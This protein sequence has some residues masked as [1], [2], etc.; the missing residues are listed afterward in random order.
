MSQIYEH[1][2]KPD[3]IVE[4]RED[5][6][7]SRYYNRDMA[8]TTRMQR[9]WG[10]RDMAALWVSMSACIPSYMIASGLISSGMNWWQAVLTVLLGNLIVLIPMV[11]NAHAGT[12]YGIPYPVYCR[13]SFGLRGA[14]IPAILR[15]LVACGWFGIQTWI[16]G[17]GIY[18]ALVVLFD[19]LKQMPPIISGIN[20]PQLLCFLAF[21]A[22]NMWIIYRGIESVRIFLNLATPVLIA[23]PIALLIWAWMKAGGAGPILSQPSQFVPGG[24]KQ[25]LFWAVFFPSLTAMVGYWATLALNIPDFS[26]FARSQRDQFVGQALGLP[27]SMGL[28]ALIGVLVTS[29]TVIIYGK[30]IWDPLDLLATFTNPIIVIISMLALA[31]ATLSTN[32]AANVVGPANDFSHVWPKLISFRTGGLITGI[33]GILM[34][35]WRLVETTNAYIYNW[36]IAYGSLL[37]AVGGILI[38]DYYLIRRTK[39]D[40]PGLYR[41]SG[42]YWYDQG[43]NWR[44]IVALAIGISLCG[45]GFLGKVRAMQVPQ[46][47][48]N[49]YDYA[50]FISLA[51]AGAVYAILM[52]VSRPRSINLPEK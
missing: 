23:I 45:P 48:L 17:K 5:V 47:W 46:I 44:A 12:R 34:Q 24:A 14:N 33:I 36:L 32:V 30:A 2:P 15:A 11:L 41:R 22:L 10:T 39:L 26:R 7:G 38:V 29:A 50:W 42:S 49:L 21:W 4:L 1:P 19:G 37:G 27:T 16:G 13:A 3:E 8:P 40:L 43:F 35:P 52:S 28:Y 20:L 18:V 6:S 31:A 51:V 25:G 9:K